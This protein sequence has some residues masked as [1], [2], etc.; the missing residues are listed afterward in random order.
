MAK[1]NI[2]D[3]KDRMTAPVGAVQI[4]PKTKKPITKKKST[5]KSTGKKKGK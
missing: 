5:T 4:D 2:D 3:Y 1:S